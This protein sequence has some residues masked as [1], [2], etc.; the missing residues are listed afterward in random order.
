[1]TAVKDQKSSPCASTLG[2]DTKKTRNLNAG[3]AFSSPIKTEA[4]RTSIE[5]IVQPSG[6]AVCQSGEEEGVRQGRRDS[7]TQGEQR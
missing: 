1:M 3:E 7:K 5:I 2:A 6:N 4:D